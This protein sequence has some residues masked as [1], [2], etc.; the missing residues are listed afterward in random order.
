LVFQNPIIKD[1]L[2]YYRTLWAINYA[3]S[4]MEWDRETYMP[5]DGVNSRGIAVAELNVLAQKL[6]LDE[7]FVNM[8]EKAGE[9]EDLNDYE[10]G[11]I[12]VLK[13]AIRIAKALPSDFVMEYSKTIE[14]A[15]IVWRDAKKKNDYNKFKPYLAKIIELTRKKA[16]YL[17]YDEHPY[18]ALIDLYEEGYKTRDVDK[19]LNPLEPGLKKIIDK[20]I[21]EDL[22]PQEHPLEKEKYDKEAMK[23]INYRILEILGYPFTRGRLDE[24][25]HSFTMPISLRDARI[26]TRYE[27]Y[28]FKRSLLSTIHEFGHALYDLQ[29]DE[30][31]EYTPICR[32]ASMGVHESRYRFHI[33]AYNCICFS[34]LVFFDY[35]YDFY[36]L[37][38]MFLEFFLVFF[39]WVYDVSSTSIAYYLGFEDVDYAHTPTKT[40]M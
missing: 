4:L 21:N 19:I 14:E 7:K 16:E 29:I 20:I 31:L 33:K 8:V 11:V 12:R 18:N 23:Y 13:R 30:R 25:T 26:T 28:D 35:C 22:F 36:F 9:I 39:G 32:G 1:I 2:K 38:M 3:I 37:S 24:S 40:I 15:S 10:K 5:L 6:L 34:W 27:G 17:G